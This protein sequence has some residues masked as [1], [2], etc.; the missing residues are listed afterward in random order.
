MGKGGREMGNWEW[1]MGA[2]Q[3]VS[4][5]AAKRCFAT[6]VGE[7]GLQSLA[8]LGPFEKAKSLRINEGWISSKSVILRGRGLPISL[9]ELLVLGGCRGFGVVTEYQT[10]AREAPSLRAEAE[11]S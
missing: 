10:P 8:I 7:G 2:G 9:V 6:R 5:S 3:W 11:L 1:G 4:G